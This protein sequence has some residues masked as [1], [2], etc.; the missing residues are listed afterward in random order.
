[1]GHFYHG[2]VFHV[3]AVYCYV[4]NSFS[5]TDLLKAATVFY[6][7]C[8]SGIQNK[9]GLL[10][11]AWDASAGGWNQLK[12]WFTHSWVILAIAWNIYTPF[13]IWALN[14]G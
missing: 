10:Y 13:T 2:C 9:Q 5:Q 14:P 4:T 11:N 7:A 12:A 8:E 6:S 1:M 3:F